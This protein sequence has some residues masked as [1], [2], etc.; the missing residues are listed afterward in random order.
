MT[1]AILAGHRLVPPFGVGGGGVGAC[2]ENWVERTD[3]S[4]TTLSYSDETD[5]HTGDVFVLLT[6]GGGGFGTSAT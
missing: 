3:G 4:K 2:G 5:V 1:A 6:P